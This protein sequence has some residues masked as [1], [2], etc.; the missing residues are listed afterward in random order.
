MP[1]SKWARVESVIASSKG[2]ALFAFDQNAHMGAL[3]RGMA[4]TFGC[5]RWNPCIQVKLTLPGRK[6]KASGR[7]CV[8]EE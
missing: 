4:R 2:Q 8:E 7:R 1:N 6:G 3:R 5:L